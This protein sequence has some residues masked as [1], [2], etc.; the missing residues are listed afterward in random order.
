MVQEMFLRSPIDDGGLHF[1]MTVTNSHFQIRGQ[2]LV[3]V[4]ELKMSVRGMA[5]RP[6]N[7]F[8]KEGKMSP[9]TMGLGF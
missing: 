6:A 5:S 8:I 4:M 3:V 2:I 9:F 7:L 1:G